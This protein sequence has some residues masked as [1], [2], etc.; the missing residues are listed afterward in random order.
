MRKFVHIL[1]LVAVI[2]FMPTCSTCKIST[3]NQIKEIKF[4]RGGGFTNQIERY[5]L[6]CKGKLRKD[7]KI[8][9]RVSSEDVERIFQ[10]ADTINTS[11]NEPDNFYWFIDIN[12]KN[13][14]KN[15]WGGSTQVDRRLKNLY[16]ELNMLLK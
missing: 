8:I 2:I 3:Q 9:G 10:M 16:N 7:G 6:D 14:H 5:S 4:G 12:G 11:V 15:L 1:L 13:D